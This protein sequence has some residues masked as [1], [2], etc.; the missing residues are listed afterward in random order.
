MVDEQHDIEAQ[1][2]SAACLVDQLRY[3]TLSG[4]HQSQPPPITH[5]VVLFLTTGG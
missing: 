5:A 2:F 1:L 3:R 4:Q